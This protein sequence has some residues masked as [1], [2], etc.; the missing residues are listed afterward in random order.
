[1]KTGKIWQT[2]SK[3]Q[4]SALDGL[5][6]EYIALM[7]IE[8]NKQGGMFG[9]L[10]RAKFDAMMWGAMGVTITPEDQQAMGQSGMTY[11]EL[12]SMKM[13][14]AQVAPGQ[15]TPDNQVETPPAPETPGSQVELTTDLTTQ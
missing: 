4:Q 6:R 2:L 7:W 11:R 15:P 1:M 12:Q 3:D 14:M 10:P 8:Q 5:C 9:M 13:Q